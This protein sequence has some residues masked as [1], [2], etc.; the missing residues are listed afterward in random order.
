MSGTFLLDPRSFSLGVRSVMLG[1]CAMSGELDW[2][3]HLCSCVTPVPVGATSQGERL[4]PN[5]FV[6][7]LQASRTPPGW[8]GYSGWVGPR[9]GRQGGLYHEWYEHGVAQARSP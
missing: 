2:R 8:S 1:G 3:Q 9:P 7:Q 4:S 5:V 6:P